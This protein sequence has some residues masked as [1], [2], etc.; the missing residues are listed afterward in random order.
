MGGG[1]SEGALP[2]CLFACLGAIW[3]RVTLV[4][5]WL[6]TGITGRAFETRLWPLL[7]WFF[8][9]TTTLAWALWM[10]HLGGH[11]VGHIDDSWLAMGTIGVAFLFDVGQ[12]GMF[13]KE[14]EM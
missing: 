4:I 13:K 10:N 6:F 5:L 3:P 11:G 9:P 12:L 8:V 1:E 7:G 14:Q 2:C